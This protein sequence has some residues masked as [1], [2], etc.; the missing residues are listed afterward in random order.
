MRSA[1]RQLRQ[2]FQ[3]LLKTWAASSVGVITEPVWKEAECI[4]ILSTGRTG[5][6][7]LARLLDLS[8][9]VSAFH[10]PTP[11]LL[12]ERKRARW[13]V[14]K[15]KKKYRKI[16]ARARGASLFNAVRHRKVYAETSARL[17]FFA[18]VIADLLPRAKFIYIHRS[19]TEIVRSGMRRGWYVDHPA[20]YA[21]VKPVVSEEASARWNDWDAFSKICW[22]WNV[23]NRFALNFCDYVEETRVLTL[24]A[25]EIFSG[26]AV[27]AIFDHINLPA[28]SHDKVERI[29][30]KKLNAQKQD[31]F[32]KGENWSRD[33]HRV[34]YNIAGKTIE[35]LDYDLPRSK[36][37]SRKGLA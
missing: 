35:Q 28:P 19:P 6:K 8:D 34:L 30:N 11:Q 17:T 31:A 12:V 14:H 16:F 24:R 7:T 21:R 22:Y 26:E 15:D 36:S 25:E 2:R 33:M 4:F 3:R 13:E 29:L 27:S 23:Y 37:P 1:F 18:P 5:T 20:D 32:P 10:E 9:R